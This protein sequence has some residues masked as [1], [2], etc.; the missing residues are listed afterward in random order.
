[1]SK[2]PPN[3]PRQA[4][5]ET[6]LRLPYGLLTAYNPRMD[7]NL[8][9][10]ALLF[11]AISLILLAYTNRFLG[12][13]TVIRNLRD[14]YE[15]KHDPRIHKQIENLRQRVYLIRNMQTFGISSLLGC[16]VAM[17]VLFL[18]W[19]EVG[20]VIF[21][22]CLLLLAISMAI[23]IYEIQISVIALEINLSDMERPS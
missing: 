19:V 6:D 12:L 4:G 10:P 9:T 21:A 7:I 23:S 22:V 15:D 11:P 13:S 20:K 18:G 14:R 16:I 8:T 5:E 1:M 3:L 17:F 2:P